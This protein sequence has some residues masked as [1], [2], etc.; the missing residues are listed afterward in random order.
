M[1]CS[2]AQASH[3]Q[4]PLNIQH[5]YQKPLYDMMLVSSEL[6]RL[7]PSGVKYNSL[8]FSFTIKP[9]SDRVAMALLVLALVTPILSAISETWLRLPGPVHKSPRDN[10]PL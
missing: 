2:I 3:R 10:S 7:K 5:I 4:S 8:Y 9:F 6:A 1:T